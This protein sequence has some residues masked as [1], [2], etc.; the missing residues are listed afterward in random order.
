MVGLASER[1]RLLPSA[2]T[3][4]RSSSAGSRN[5]PTPGRRS[6]GQRPPAHND[7]AG[8]QPTRRV[9]QQARSLVHGSWSSSGRK[10]QQH[11]SQRRTTS[12]SPPG[13]HAEVKSLMPAQGRQAARDHQPPHFRGSATTIVVR[14]SAGPAPGC[15][16]AWS[17]LGGRTD[18]GNDFYP[19]HRCHTE[20]DEEPSALGKEARS[21]SLERL[22]RDPGIPSRGPL[23]RSVPGHASCTATSPT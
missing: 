18:K 7:R 2:P 22:L 11:P 1:C 5:A 10:S 20:G 4:R 8:Q 23:K 6:C 16:A 14:P 17:V 19:G 12:R 9:A 3:W 13:H 15:P 21:T